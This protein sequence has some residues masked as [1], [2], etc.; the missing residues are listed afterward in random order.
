M[1]RMDRPY[2]REAGQGAPTLVCL[3]S[4]AA[5]SGQWRGLMELV[6]PRHRVLAFDSYGSGKSPEWPSDSVITLDDEVDFIDPVLRDVEGP[7]VFVGHSYGAGIA[8][9]AAMRHRQRV[10]AVAVYEPTIF[11][12][13]EAEGPPPNDAD[14]IRDAVRR[15]AD[16]LDAGDRDAAAQS[17]IDYW[18]APGAW[19]AT[20][21]A[22]KPAI[23]ASS[24]NIRRWAHALMKEPTPLADF[25]AL[26]MP[27]LVVLGSESTQSAHGVARRLVPV[28]P[29]AQVRELAGIGHMGPI[30][31]PDVVNAEIDRFLRE[32]G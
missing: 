17:F 19:A 11:A 4:N 27:V 20:P 25:A 1:P 28:L 14:G 18:M 21:E 31:H 10:R 6:A 22:R 8:L 30:T 2:Y 15:A 3:H 26:D 12:L 9:K 13:I 32:L 5:H 7:L 24:V 16:A 29:R 23:A